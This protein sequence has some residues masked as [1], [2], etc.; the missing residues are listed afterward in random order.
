MQQFT[1]IISKFILNNLLTRILKIA[2]EDWNAV[3]S[4][5]TENELWEYLLVA[6]PDKAV[7][8]K[9]IEEKKRFEQ[10]YGQEEDTRFHPHITIAN[11]LAKE[12]MEETF[13]RWIQNICNLQK[14]FTVTLNNYN[15]FPSSG[16][17]LRV[18]DTEPFKRLANA[19][20]ILDGFMQSNDC[21]P[22]KLVS[23]PHVTFVAG[24]SQYTY[25]S[26]INKYSRKTFHESFKVDKLILLKRDAYMKCHLIN[27]FFLPQPLTL[28][29]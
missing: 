13:I 19:L 3:R 26:A 21:P 8:K 11:F 1:K 28:F 29:D 16:L 5:Q 12:A 22:L 25:E 15:A 9:I 10:E 14:S 20:K 18:Q 4:L 6:H 2:M 7:N 27:S 23:K 24:L 17:Y